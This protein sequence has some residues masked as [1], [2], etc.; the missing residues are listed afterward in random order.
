MI[1]P[2]NTTTSPDVYIFVNGGLVD[3]VTDSAGHEVENAHI[4]DY[5][6]EGQCPICYAAMP[7][8]GD[9]CATCGYNAGIGT[10]EEALRAA[11][12]AY[13]PAE[14]YKPARTVPSQHT[15]AP[16]C[17][18]GNLIGYTEPGDPPQVHTVLAHIHNGIG[19]R[20]HEFHD[21]REA[22]AR[23]IAAA[24]DLLNALDNAEAALLELLKATEWDDL[25]DSGG[26]LAAARR[27]AN[28]LLYNI[29]ETLKKAR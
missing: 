4:I 8:D 23:L 2:R 15:P 18:D 16:W 17:T 21:Q 5:D 1:N 29:H 13:L 12:A 19:N 7:E 6:N 22:N 3:T 11:K 25:E 27:Q 10:K 24:P 20:P 14:E 9:T 26:P 28:G